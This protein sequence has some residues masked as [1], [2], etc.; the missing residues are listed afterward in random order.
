MNRTPAV[1]VAGHDRTRIVL[2]DDHVLFRAG[3]R[4]LLDL[5]TTWEVVGEAHGQADLLRLVEPHRPALVL[6]DLHLGEE[7]GLEL[8]RRVLK[9]H[10]HTKVIAVTSDA[11]PE[12]VHSAVVAGVSGY[13]LKGNA[14]EELERALVAVLAGRTY[15]CAEVSS[16]VINNLRF[17]IARSPRQAL[18]T[19]RE[20]DLVRL[21]A[22]GNRTKEIAE[23]LGVTPKSAETLRLR[24]MR[25]LDMDSTA[26]VTRFAIREGLVKA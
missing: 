1:P 19:S 26:A 18:L 25:K 2:V 12:I 6:M 20:T 7:C 9:A 22:D 23:A 8:T 5:S 21:I 16:T 15:F 3:V 17:G 24:L 11:S 10:P 13:I 14:A 4:A